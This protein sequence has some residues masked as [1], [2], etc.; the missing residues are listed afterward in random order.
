MSN[1]MIAKFVSAGMAEGAHP[2]QTRPAPPIAAT[3]SPRERAELAGLLDR[4]VNG[5][6]T[7]SDCALALHWSA[8][9]AVKTGKLEGLG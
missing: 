2:S 4:L 3:I 7:I 5:K 8:R 9:L 6:A 1:D